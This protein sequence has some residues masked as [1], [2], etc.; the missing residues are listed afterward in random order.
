ME[1]ITAII[2]DDE[3]GARE[4]MERLLA[5]FS[6]IE[7]V[8]N[9]N[10]VDSALVAIFKYHPDIVFLDIDMPVK[11]GFDL[12][13]ELK[14]FK[15]QPSI[16]F[17]TAYNKYAI[18]AIRHSA[19]DYLVKPVD[20]SELQLSIS[21]FKALRGKQDLSNN[22]EHLLSCL[23]KKKIKFNTYDGF[24]FLDPDEI[25]YCEANGNYTNI[26]LDNDDRE[27]MVTMNL[28]SIIQVLP[29]KFIRINRSVTINKAYLK[30]VNR[31]AKIC[32]LSSSTGEFEFKVPRHYIKELEKV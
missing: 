4:I 31:K 7:V 13:R 11:N 22:I 23:E 17:V 12:V 2:V 25:I 3:K 6:D 20:I 24:I 28:G 27:K 1:K 9:N 29:N 15:H 19:F 8:S 26:Y 21:R 10:S 5:D 14:D 32:V 16:I 30:E 18:E